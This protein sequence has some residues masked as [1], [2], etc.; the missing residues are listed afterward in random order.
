MT[1]LEE[2]LTRQLQEC[3]EALAA[4]QREN[5]L[6]RQKVEL[7]IK[8]IF[9]SSSEQLDRGQLELFLN[10]SSTPDLPFAPEPVVERPARKST[11]RERGPRLPE[12]NFL[13]GRSTTGSG[14]KGRS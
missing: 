8:R 7:L 5:A 13:A 3:R 6:L 9:G 4:S 11:S 10:P 14:A 12:V 2:Q 1:A